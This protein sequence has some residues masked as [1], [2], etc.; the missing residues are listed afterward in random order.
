MKFS[1][2]SKP[3]VARMDDAQFLATA[4]VFESIVDTNDSSVTPE[5][6]CENFSLLADFMKS[7]SDDDIR[8]VINNCDDL[9]E[10]F[11]GNIDHFKALVHS[12][13][14][15]ENFI[16][17]A[18]V[19]G[20]IAAIVHRKD[21]TLKVLKPLVEECKQR[22]NEIPNERFK[23]GILNLHTTS[24]YLPYKA[25]W[26]KAAKAVIELA[27]YIKSTSPDNFKP[28]EARA[29]LAGSIFLKGHKEKK[30]SSS[31]N[32]L[33]FIPIIGWWKMWKDMLDVRERGWSSREDFSSA[34]KDCEGLCDAM[35]VCTTAMSNIKSKITPENKKAAKDMIHCC[36]FVLSEAGHLARGCTTA[37][38][39]LSSGILSRIWQQMHNK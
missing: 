22:L 26:P 27:N 16:K 18:L 5:E 20:L 24:K 31:G 11:D 34:L 39:K 2:N 23:I 29:K 15:N 38:K 25:D 1:V 19:D 33:Y 17:D 21:A 4:Q 32:I 28:E 8:D 3:P 13:M 14:S 30:Q 7:A 12:E 35:D 36:K 10:V 9:R 37:V 6:S